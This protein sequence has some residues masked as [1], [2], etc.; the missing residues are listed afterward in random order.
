MDLDGD[1]R[2]DVIWRHKTNG[3]NLGCV[4][5]SAGAFQSCLA[6]QPIADLQWHIISR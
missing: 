3:S 6:I 2:A 4:N 5:F 1:G